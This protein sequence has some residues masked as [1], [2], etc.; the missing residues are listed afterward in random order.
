MRISINPLLRRAAAI[1]PNSPNLAQEM[2]GTV[3]LGELLLQGGVW[4]S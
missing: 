3:N 4:A 2:G 1:S